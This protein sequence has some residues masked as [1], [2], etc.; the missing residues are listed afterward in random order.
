MTFLK[1]KLSD[2]AQD[3]LSTLPAD[4]R[5]SFANLSAAFL[6]RF[7]PKELEQFRFAKE[8]FNQK[9][10]PGQSVDA[11]IT[12]LKKKA[13]IVGMEA[14]SQLWAALNG[15]LPHIAS[16]VMER[17]VPESLDEL[18]GYARVG[19]ITRR[20]SSAGTS[21]TSALTL[22]LDQLNQQ[23]VLLTS[24]MASM[25]VA[26]LQNLQNNDSARR[27]V[28][29]HDAYNG[30]SRSPSPFRPEARSRT[31]PRNFGR[32]EKH[33]EDTSQQPPRW[34]NA[35]RSQ[36]SGRTVVYQ[37]G[38]RRPPQQICF[39]CGRARHQNPSFCPMLTQECYACGK[40]GHAARMYRSKK[41]QF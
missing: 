37:G 16:F 41:S 9:Q 6:D 15:L 12:D 11:F 19:E 29:F 14:K 26:N 34:Q 33:R 25:S 24:K 22:Q 17:A 27:Q 23:M 40:T 13:D 36:S 1:L 31:P 32:F 18:L 21:D 8:L 20:N 30:R 5:N 28:S 39:K 38:E 35:N 3:W 2:T 10:Q 7:Q 4:K